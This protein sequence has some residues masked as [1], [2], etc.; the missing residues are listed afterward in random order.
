M[1]IAGGRR[2]RVGAG[3]A[4]LVLH[5]SLLLG[6][7]V[8]LFPFAW[9]LSASLKNQGEIFAYPPHLIPHVIRWHN[10]RQILDVVPFEEQ[11]ESPFVGLLQVEAS[12]AGVPVIPVGAAG[13]EP[14]TFGP[15]DQ[16]ANQA[17]P[18]PAARTP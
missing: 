2:R 11:D 17:A 9:M 18:R 12:E 14:A 5:V 15:P 13:F 16:R 8:M 3:A 1:A 4:R 10:F 6:A 7:A